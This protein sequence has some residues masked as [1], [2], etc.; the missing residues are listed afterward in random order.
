MA[1]LLICGFILLKVV[2]GDAC[3]SG[4]FTE[5]GECCRVCP[6]GFGVAVECG[7]DDT[8][9][10]PCPQ[11]TFSSSEDLGRCLPCSQCPYGVPTLATCSAVEDTQCECDSGFFY[12]RAYGLCAPCSKCK[13]GEGAAQECGPKGDTQCRLCV[14]G[15]FSEEHANTKPCQTCT[16]CTDSEV[17]IRACMPNSDTLCM[18]KKLHILSRD[19]PSWSGV[20]EV[21]AGG[22]SPA[23]GTPK[24]TPQGE[25]GGNNILAY[26]SVLAAVV[27]GLLV[28]VAYK[29]W[30]SCKQKQ[31]LSKAR[32]AELGAS[33]EGE[34][35]QSD[36]GVFL[37]SQSL[38]DNQ[39]CKGTKRDSKQDTRLYINL[40]PH[41]QEEVE[42]LLQEGA[43]RGWRQLGQALGYEAE[44]LDLFGRG[45]APARTLLSNWAL[46]EG[47]TLGLLCSALARIERPDVVSALNCPA[48]GASVV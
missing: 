36:S 22:G 48:Q 44:Q 45:E 34:K 16:Q 9:C 12:F 20:E 3:A 42:R 38:Q 4:Q 41:R 11:G 37:D 10:T 5:S 8:K 25:K 1:P 28:Y 7:K 35:L 29:C 31:A 18:D 26:V 6:A 32:A 43:G 30:R 40:P 21:T 17:E 24:F 39:P 14:P 27:L 46:K 23:P 15:T 19:T 2:F 13:R 47:S 33:P